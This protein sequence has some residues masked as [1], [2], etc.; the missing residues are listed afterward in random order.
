MVVNSKYLIKFFIIFVIGIVFWFI[1]YPNSISQD[2]WHSLIIFVITVIYLMMNFLPMSM[3]LLMSILILNLSNISD[4]NESLSGFG[5]NIVWLVVM[6]FFISN[7]I[8][9][10]KLGNRVAYYLLYRFGKSTI[11]ISY[12]LVFTEFILAPV[13]PSAIA[14]AGGIVFPIAKSMSDHIVNKSKMNNCKIIYF[15][16]QSC[17]NANVI[18]SSMFLT[19]MAGNPLISKLVS[20]IGINITWFQWMKGAIIP[21]LVNLILLPMYLHYIIKP[22]NINVVEIQSVARKYLIDIGAW[23]QNQ[24]F[25]IATLMFLIIGWIFGEKLLNIDIMTISFI[26]FAMMLFGRVITVNDVVSE[27]NAWNTLLW[28]GS[29]ITL[30][31]QL[32]KSGATAW[33]GGSISSMI[34]NHNSYIM[35]VFCALLF[36]YMHY[37]F[38]S[39]TVYA[40]VMLVSFTFIMQSLGVPVFLS[41]MMLAYLVNLSGCLTQYTI[42]SAPI[43][44]AAS[45][46]SVKDWW[47]MGFLVSLLNFLVWL[48]IGS[49]WW[50]IIGWW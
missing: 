16:M 3:I 6:A 48:I 50:K 46:M 19:A 30:S 39:I 18:S 21:G 2:G 23:T 31:N 29:F 32:T 25:V 14:R 36:F 10:S 4:A 33:I 24:I 49:I 38:A 9:K 42:S 12:C 44:Y 37:F 28:F 41:A 1:P 26:G 35:I 27:K 7:A 15:I 17:F 40:T 5:N 47:K 13:I 34:V 11:S 20:N 8:I 43:L 22:S 45:N